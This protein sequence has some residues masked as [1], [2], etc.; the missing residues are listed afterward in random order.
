[1]KVLGDEKPT[2]DTET[3]PHDPIPS[4]M[5]VFYLGVLGSYPL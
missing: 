2:E 5:H 1:M 3:A 4:P